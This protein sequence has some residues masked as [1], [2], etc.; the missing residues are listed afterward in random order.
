VHLHAQRT[1]A[2]V[3]RSTADSTVHSNRFDTFS[4]DP[5]IEEWCVVAAE[6]SSEALFGKRVSIEQVEEGH[7]LAPKFDAA[8]LIPCVTTAGSGLPRTVSPDVRLRRKPE[9]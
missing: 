5:F 6:S 1:A 8:G 4:S 3:G 2:P 7:E 9:A